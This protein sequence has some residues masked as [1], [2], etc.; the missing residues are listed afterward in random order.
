MINTATNSVI[1]YTNCEVFKI[2]DPKA[3]AAYSPAKPIAE[4]IL[5]PIGEN[6][7]LRMVIIGAV[8][9]IITSAMNISPVGRHFQNRGL[10]IENINS[11]GMQLAIHGIE[12]GMAIFATHQ[13]AKQFGSQFKFHDALALEALRSLEL[14]VISFGYQYVM[15]TSEPAET[16]EHLS[17][18]GTCPAYLNQ[19]L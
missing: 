6:P 19:T 3:A 12:S 14:G 16:F 4:K 7:F 18:L 13:I 11:A 8:R 1:D 9:T 10:N 15:G 2:T 17:E 5:K